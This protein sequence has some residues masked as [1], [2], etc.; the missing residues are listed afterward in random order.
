MKVSTK[1]LVINKDGKILGLRRSET[2]PHK[3]FQ[4]D[5]P[6]GLVEEG[7]DLIEAIKRE[8]KEETDLDVEDVSLLHAIA[9][10]SSGGDYIITIAYRAFSKSDEVK[11][12]WEHDQFEWLSAEEFTSRETNDRTK[13][14][15]GMLNK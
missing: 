1:A 5:L 4:W 12:S 6:G 10:K 2:H 9:G 14:F 11:I 8:I 3:P 7:E 15:I 13:M